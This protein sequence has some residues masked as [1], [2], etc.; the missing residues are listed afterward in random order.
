[1]TQKR[2]IL[3]TGAGRGIGA[4][5]CRTLATPDNRLIA[6]ARS[7]DQLEALQEELSSSCA[8]FRCIPADLAC[9]DDVSRLVHEVNSQAGALDVLINNAGIA[10]GRPLADTTLA[11][12]RE[13]MALNLDAVFLLTRDLLALLGESPCGQIINI[14]SDAS[15]RGIRN[16]SC[17]CASKF[18]LRG[19]TMALRQELA[20]TGTRVNLVMPGPVNTTIIAKV[21][22]R[23][24]LIQ[25]EDVAE[26][27]AG[28]IQLPRTADVWETLIEPAP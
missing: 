25:P 13:L 19:F 12:W 1:M 17:Y 20:E 7:L 2:T 18:A 28:L 11:Q 8:D 27:V 15:I 24:D 5:I 4:A 22:N 3:I 14:G 6:T 10:W 9:P 26:I 21:A 23:T 16:M